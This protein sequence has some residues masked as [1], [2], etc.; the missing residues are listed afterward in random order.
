MKVKGRWTSLYR[1]IDRA[2]NRGD[3]LLSEKRDKA[4]TEAYFR[5]AQ[6]VAGALARL[7]RFAGSGINENTKET[8]VTPHSLLGRVLIQPLYSLAL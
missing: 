7:S 5:S 4:A 6:R 3:V 1:A 8:L 2:G